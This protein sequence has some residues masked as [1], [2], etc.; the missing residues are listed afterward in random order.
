MQVLFVYASHVVTLLLVAILQFF[1]LML[2]TS[3]DLAFI[4][5]AVGVIFL[6]VVLSFFFGYKYHFLQQYG[7]FVETRTK[8]FGTDTSDSTDSSEYCDFIYFCVHYQQSFQ[9]T[10]S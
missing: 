10:L 5:A 2:I 8:T 4:I 1:N 6:Q 7:H 3:L 9:G